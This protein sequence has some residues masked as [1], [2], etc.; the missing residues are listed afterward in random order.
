MKINR[1]VFRLTA[2]PMWGRFSDGFSEALYLGRFVVEWVRRR[3]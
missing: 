3:G 1:F 2:F